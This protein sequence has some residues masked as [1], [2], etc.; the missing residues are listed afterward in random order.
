MLHAF[1]SSLGRRLDALDVSAEA[2]S[3]LDAQ[4][5]RLAAAEIPGS[6]DSQTQSKL[7]RAVAESF[8]HGFRVLM[9]IAAALALLG[10]LAALVL[11][12]GKAVRRSVAGHA[13]PA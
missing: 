10:A 11:I 12:E 4:R 3:S 8:V 7:K 6:L 9:L 2:R 5:V 13:A 1:D